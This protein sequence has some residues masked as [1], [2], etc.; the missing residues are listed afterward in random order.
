[1]PHAPERTLRAG[2]LSYKQSFSR[3]TYDGVV[4]NFAVGRKEMY[5]STQPLWSPWSVGQRTIRLWQHLGSFRKICTWLI[6]ATR[7]AAFCILCLDF[8]STQSTLHVGTTTQLYNISRISVKM[9]TAFFLSKECAACNFTVHSWTRRH[10][11]SKELQLCTKPHSVTSQKKTIFVHYRLYTKM[12][13]D[14]TL[15]Q[16]N[17]VR[18]F[19]IMILPRHKEGPH[20]SRHRVPLTPFRDRVDGTLD[21]VAYQS[22]LRGNVTGLFGVLSVFGRRIKGMI[23]LRPELVWTSDKSPPSALL[24]SFSF[25]TLLSWRVV[26]NCSVVWFLERFG[27]CDMEW[28]EGSVR[29]YWNAASVPTFLE[30][31]WLSWTLCPFSRIFLQTN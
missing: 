20:L 31:K 13:Q 4:R 23:R 7:N 29:T 2:N 22:W 30:Q 17:Q 9:E 25:L 16:L 19:Y 21:R 28:T 14:P 8:Y 15:S 26:R 5:Q 1:M 18:T 6:A 27:N 10:I 11:S 3:E 24:S 12:L